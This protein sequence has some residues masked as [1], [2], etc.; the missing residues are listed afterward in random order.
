MR[1]RL[2]VITLPLL[3]VLWSVTA[4]YAQER[5]NADNDTRQIEGDAQIAITI[6]PETR[7]SASRSG[8]RPQV[9]KCGSAIVVPV[10]IANQGFLTSRLQAILIDPVSAGVAVEFS[11]EPLKGSGEERRMLR[12]ILKTPGLHDVTIAFRARNSM[13]DLDDG[14]DR[15]HILMNC[16]CDAMC[17]PTAKTHSL[18][19]SFSTLRGCSGAMGYLAIGRAR[20]ACGSMRFAPSSPRS[21]KFQRI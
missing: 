11:S 9:G 8:G 2:T 7:I 17:A 16:I 19:C 4:V 3:A 12:V 10:Y 6:N 15:V 13:P 20:H 21:A 1:N 18:S 14:R 5:I